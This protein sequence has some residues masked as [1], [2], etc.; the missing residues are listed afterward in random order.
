M[1]LS[2]E[3][4]EKLRN[5]GLTVDQIIKFERGDVPT[6]SIT[7][8][9]QFAKTETKGFFGKA[10]DFATSLIG[11]GKLAEGVGQALAAPGVQRKLSKV[12]ETAAAQQEQIIKLEQ[13][14][15]QEQLIE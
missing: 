10:R 5:K 1:P 11:G 9:D 12:Q 8:E 13:L 7:Q 15:Q 14:I 6:E 3:Q 4:F 2:K